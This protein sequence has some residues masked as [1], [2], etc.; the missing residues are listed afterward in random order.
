[1]SGFSAAALRALGHE[2]RVEDYYPTLAEKAEAAG[3]QLVPRWRDTEIWAPVNRR[4]RRAINEFRP[5]L[6]LTIYGLHISPQTLT[7]AR[8]RGIVRACW[9]INDP[10]QS[11]PGVDRAA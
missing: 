6:L 3:K 11:Q 4:L 2:V 10:F 5:D 9:W 7:L 8:E 1:M